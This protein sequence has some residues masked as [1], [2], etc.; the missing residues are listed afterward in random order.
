[1]IQSFFQPKAVE[2]LTYQFRAGSNQV[3]G[4]GSVSG[5]GLRRL[6]SLGW[7]LNWESCQ[8]GSSPKAPQ[9]DN[10]GG[11]G[12]ALLRRLLLTMMDLP[13]FFEPKNM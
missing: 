7:R 5:L 2:M 11:S 12:C 3:L 10:C 9:L 1:M 13:H 4:S 6:Y 8:I